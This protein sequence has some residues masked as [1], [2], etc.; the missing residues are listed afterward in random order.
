VTAIDFSDQLLEELRSNAK[1]LGIKTINSDIRSFRHVT[2]DDAELIVCCGDTLSHLENG[3]QIDNLLADIATS[4]KAGGKVLLSFRN[5]STALTGDDRFIAV[6]SDDTRLL[7]CVLD[8]EDERV[9]VTDV[10]HEKEGDAW[11]QKVSSYFKARTSAHDVAEALKRNG[12]EIQFHE[13]INR[14]TFILAVKS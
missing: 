12:M 11:K 7:T 2:G 8:Y 10:L 14:M 5:Y 13:V 9:R 1:G 4:L 3:M 6:K